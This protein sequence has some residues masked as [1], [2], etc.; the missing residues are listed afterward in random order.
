MNKTIYN[1]KKR[2]NNKTNNIK[3]LKTLYYG[4]FISRKL[5]FRLVNLPNF[6]FHFLIFLT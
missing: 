1:F 6:Y 4:L 2:F 3:I 5:L